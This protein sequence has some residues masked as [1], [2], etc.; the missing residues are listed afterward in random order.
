MRYRTKRG[1]CRPAGYQF[2]GTDREGWFCGPFCQAAA[3][4][5]IAALAWV[6]FSL[7]SSLGGTLTVV[8][9]VTPGNHPH[10]VMCPRAIRLAQGLYAEEIGN[11]GE[12]LGNFPQAFSHPSLIS[13]GSVG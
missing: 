4:A 12:Q 13:A 1:A 5:A 8:S 6:H 2:A 10:R 3:P 7:A 9:Q 11:T